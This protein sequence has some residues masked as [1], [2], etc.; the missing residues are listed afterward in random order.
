[1]KENQINDFNQMEINT[2]NFLEYMEK[3]KPID[4]SFLKKAREHNDSLCKPLGSL[5][6]L[7]EIYERLYAI[8]KGNIPTFKKVVT[9]YASDNGVYEENVSL[10]PQDTTYKVCL[11]I[12][13][14][15]SGLGKLSEFYGVDV[16][17]EDLGVLNDV[18]NHTDYKILRGTSNIAKGPA[19]S[20]ETALKGLLAGFYKTKNL[21]DKGYNIF[22]AGEMGVGNTT[23][24]AAVISALLKVEPEDSTG[25]GSGIT[26]E[27]YLNKINV[28]KK[29]ISVNKPF[30]DV[31]DVCAKL[32]GLD[33]LGMAGT[34]LSCAF[35]G[36]P[37][38]LDGVISMAALLI[39]SRINP[40]V[41]DYAFSSHSSAEKG[42]RLTQ[43][44][45]KL[46]PFLNL[47]MRLGEGSGCPIA[48]SI[49]EAS[50]FTMQ[51]MATFGDVNVSKNDYVDIRKE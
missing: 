1:M 4:E 29:A 23:T 48:M 20:R 27:M 13:S 25:F 24:S 39:A 8:F 19:M 16:Y 35:Y 44:E 43:K 34:Y 18:L 45:L 41:L 9:V 46:K 11:N 14:K 49:M 21:I 12:I 7:E 50:V 5:G 38:V 26:D 40:T 33:I 6:S 37:F 47:N 51:N 32:S 22:G 42:A 3:I 28:I 36:F 17:L 15:G 31:T 10:N 2:G 30:T